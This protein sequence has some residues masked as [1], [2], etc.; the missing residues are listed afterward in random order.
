MVDVT[1]PFTP[2]RAVL[3][4]FLEEDGIPIPFQ[5]NVLHV[6][7]GASTVMTVKVER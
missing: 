5:G 6:P 7:T 2:R 4:N 3:T 1:L